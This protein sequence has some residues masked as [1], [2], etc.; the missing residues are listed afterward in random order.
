VSAASAQAA[1]AGQ[2]GA[3]YRP[4][5]AGGYVA[6]T[7]PARGTYAGTFR[8]GTGSRP[9]VS[10]PPAT[11]H[12]G[13]GSYPAVGGGTGGYPTVGPRGQA[14]QAAPVSA[15]PVSS[16][17]V[18]SAP[19]SSA[20]ISGMPVSSAP[21]SGVP[22]S[23]HPGSAGHLAVPP[24]PGIP[25]AGRRP[26]RM[27]QPRR[28][29]EG[30]PAAGGAPGGGAGGAGSWW[31]RSG[32]S[33]GPGPGFGAPVPA[34]PP[35]EPVTGGT[36]ASGLPLRVPMAQLPADQPGRP[37][38]AA[39]TGAARGVAPRPEVDPETTR[40]TL[41]AFYSGVRRAENEETTDLSG[42][43]VPWEQERQ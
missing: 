20:P 18:S 2:A 33:G 15:V 9:E 40:S 28:S 7:G 22:V 8:T 4:A 21:I 36:S 38:A 42:Y 25:V 6:P 26:G 39:P 5:G 16:T 3:A 10:T 24:G 17:P 43:R 11:L 41:A 19:T 14:A 34:G 35:A 31:S 12:S 32:G 1:P 27:T 13:T 23:A 37:G 30:Q 29:T